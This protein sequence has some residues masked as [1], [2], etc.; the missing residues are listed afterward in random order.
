MLIIMRIKLSWVAHP[1]FSSLEEEDGGTRE[2]RGGGGRALRWSVL[3][4]TF[5]MYFMAYTFRLQQCKIFFVLPYPYGKPP[6]KDA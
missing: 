5:Q 1:T 3:K 2:G 6:T 4:K